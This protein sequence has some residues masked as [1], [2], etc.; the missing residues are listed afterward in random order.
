MLLEWKIFLN[1]IETFIV[2][3]IINSEL[4]PL[5]TEH[6]GVEFCG[7]WYT[8]VEGSTQMFT[9]CLTSGSDKMDKFFLLFKWDFDDLLELRLA[10]T[11]FTIV[12]LASFKKVAH[13]FFISYVVWIIYLATT[14]KQSLFCSFNFNYL[15][16]IIMVVL[17]F[18]LDFNIK[19]IS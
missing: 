4:S 14:I 8:I 18:L 19:L 5:L 10:C 9:S 13:S 12:V 15:L 11:C 16:S 1:I 3:F 2:I 17:N 6:C 7:L